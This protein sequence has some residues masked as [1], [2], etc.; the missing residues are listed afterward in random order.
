MGNQTYFVTDREL[1]WPLAHEAQL[2]RRQSVE[3]KFQPGQ[4]QQD[5]A[6]RF[7]GLIVKEKPGTNTPQFLLQINHS[8]GR[9][10]ILDVVEKHYRSPM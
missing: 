10:E 5:R 7:G 8:H 2:G 9:E 3:S 1:K 4:I 6:E